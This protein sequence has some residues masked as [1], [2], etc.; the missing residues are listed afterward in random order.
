MAYQLLNGEDS[1]AD[2]LCTRAS[3]FLP[4]KVGRGELVRTPGNH[5]HR[6]SVNNLGRV[7]VQRTGDD[8]KRMQTGI[9][10]ATLDLA[11]VGYVHLG[12][13]SEVLLAKPE[14]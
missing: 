5:F 13:L 9:G 4:N 10:L 2:L 11:D 14:F 6:Y 7:H 1:A 8:D 12:Q 3:V